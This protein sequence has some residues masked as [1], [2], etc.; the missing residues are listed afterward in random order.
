[1]YCCVISYR[2]GF[3]KEEIWGE[4]LGFKCIKT[5]KLFGYFLNANFAQ[6]CHT[7]YHRVDGWL[8]QKLISSPVGWKSEMVSALL[9]SLET[10][11]LGLQKTSYV[12]SYDFP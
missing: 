10:S 12:S 11:V 5:P 2:V 7:E 1:M 4:I 8:K 9:I 6:D 3:F